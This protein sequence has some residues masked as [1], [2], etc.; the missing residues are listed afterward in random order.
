VSERIF[1]EVTKLQIDAWRKVALAVNTQPDSG[2]AGNREVIDM[3]VRSGGWLRSVTRYTYSNWRRK[4]AA[5]IMF[6]QLSY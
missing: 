4:H 5:D 6:Q 3:V 2:R 1:T